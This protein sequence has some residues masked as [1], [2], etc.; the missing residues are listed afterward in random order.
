[1]VTLAASVVAVTLAGGAAAQNRGAAGAGA[2][3]AGSPDK[4][5]EDKLLGVLAARE[6]DGLLDYY[7]QKHN[8]P[9]DRQASIRSIAAWRE[10]NNPNLP[11]ARR[12]QLLM[13]GVKGIKNFIASTKDTELLMTRAGQ[14]IEFGMKGQVTQIE[15]FGETPKSQAEL[16]EI[17]D[18]VMKLLDRT[19]EECEA[20]ENQVLAGQTRP[21]PQ[22]MAKWQALDDRLNTA[23]WTKAFASYGLALSLD[24]ADAK[25]KEVAD[26]AITFLKDFEDPQYQREATVKLQIGKLNVAKGDMAAAVA[27]FNEALK[28]PGIDKGTQF[29]AMYGVALANVLAK[30]PDLAAGAVVD[31]QKFVADNFQGEDAKFASA[32]IGLLDYRINALR[33]SQ[34]Q[35]PDQKKKFAEAGDAA[36]S[37]VMNENPRMAPAIRRLMLEKLPPDADL[38]KLDTTVLQSLM[39]RG[40]DE[41]NRAKDGVADERG[42]PALQRALQA[43]A[44]IQKRK[45]RP[46]TNADAV[47]VAAFFEPFF[48]AKLGDNA[49]SAER[50]LDYLKNYPNNKD[51]AAETLNNALAAVEALR[52]SP[53]SGSQRVGDLITQTWKEAV[54]RGQKQYAFVYGKRLSD[55]AKTPADYKAAAAA[56]R[57][58][59]EN[60][61]AVLHARFYELSALQEVLDDKSLVPAARVILVGDIQKL[62]ADVNKRIDAALATA[63]EDQKPRLKFYK[64]SATLLAA[65]LLQKESKDNAGVLKLLGGFEETAKGLPQE[66]KLDAT[67]LR[68]RVNAY[69]AVGKTQAAVDEVKKLVA[70]QQGGNA[71]VLFSMIGQMDDAYA[72][73][74]AAN[75]QDAMR[76]NSAA[77]VALI[78][79]LIEQTKDEATR[80]KYKQWKADLVLRA[81]RNEQ[82]AARRSQYLAEAQRTFTELMGLAKEGTPQFDTMRYK[83][84][85]VSYELKD[86]KKV[87]QELGQLI[88]GR[89]LGDPDLREASADGG[90]TFRENPVYWEGLLRYM[91]ANWELSKTDDSPQMKEAIANARDTLKTLYIN[92]G[93]NVG[94]D[95]LRDEYAKLKA[96]MLP[97]WDETQLTPAGGT[98][99][100]PDK[101][102]AGA[103]TN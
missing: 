28:A 91:Q 45:G 88:A 60:H 3:A 75:D 62:A 98:A 7:F 23:R 82:D 44:E 10:M 8:I 20:Q 64:V 16:N 92:R 90:E 27:K 95:R 52:R 47:D 69:M 89:R 41:V 65:D 29:E 55:R 6:M 63:K 12:R 34:A 19:I 35:A 43:S 101:P 21:N 71:N 94:G 14:L 40:V 30:K 80:N 96:E 18:A 78:T 39:A 66:D 85:L 58:V 57:A 11:A 93:K 2:S 84:A 67:A 59:P 97:G 51:R 53:E 76:Q 74:K 26:A 50:A 103:G 100:Q 9:A 81:A 73:A 36:L 22:I 68:L 37:K 49:K 77:Q 79:P 56:L 102:A 15:Y 24:P 83:L 4:A 13:D 87:Q 33:A 72:K 86:Y 54:D 32:S 31:V 25:R 42:K 1:M 5:M 70:S 99:T 61:P 38:T 46:G 48:W 17:A